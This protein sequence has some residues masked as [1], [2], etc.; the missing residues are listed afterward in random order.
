M[1]FMIFAIATKENMVMQ[2]DAPSWFVKSK[3]NMKI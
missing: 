3:K 1:V 2:K